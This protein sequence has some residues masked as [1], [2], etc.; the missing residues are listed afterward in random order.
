MPRPLG[1]VLKSSASLNQNAEGM[2]FRVVIANGYTFSVPKW[3]SDRQEF[4][5]QYKKYSIKHKNY[6]MRSSE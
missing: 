4:H 5:Q 6:C 1:S 2:L 3:H